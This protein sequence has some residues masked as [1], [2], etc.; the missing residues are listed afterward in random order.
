MIT[1][2]DWIAKN[3]HCA[4]KTAIVI[5]IAMGPVV[6]PVATAVTALVTDLG[7]HSEIRMLI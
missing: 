7:S 4:K 2:V 1:H 3:T 6:T 5:G